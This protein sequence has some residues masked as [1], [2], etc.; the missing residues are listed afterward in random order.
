MSYLVDESGTIQPAIIT[1]TTTHQSNAAGIPIMEQP[2]ITTSEFVDNVVKP[3]YW[4]TPPACHP[5]REWIRCPIIIYI[6]IIIIGLIINLWAL[7]RIPRIDNSGKQIT[8]GQ[9]W[10]AGIVGIGFYLIVA[11]AVGWWIYERCRMCDSSS[12]WMT[13]VISI[14]VAI[15]LAPI[16][17][18][19]IGGILGIGFLWTANQQPNPF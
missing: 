8:T 4:T 15:I 13:F 1:Q 12:Y 7:F 9:M 6:I 17:G 5:G 10:I 11:L 2:G 3:S 18:L 14:L 19:I 16:T